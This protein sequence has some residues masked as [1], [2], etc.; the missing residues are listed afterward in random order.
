MSRRF[1][2]EESRHNWYADIPEGQELSRDQVNTGAILRIADSLEKM[3]QP[4][5]QLLRETE[6]L[7][8]EVAFLLAENN[9]LTRS[10]AALRGCLKK[11]KKVG[12]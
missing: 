4:F 11:A 9:R 2:I 7:R 5:V 12:E 10:N 6:G 8:D 1:Y 3:E